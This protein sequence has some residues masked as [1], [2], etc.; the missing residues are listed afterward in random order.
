MKDSVVVVEVVGSLRKRRAPSL[1]SRLRK[2]VAGGRRAQRE[3]FECILEI[4]R[5]VAK[6]DPKALPALV[7]LVGRAAQA[8]AMTTVLR[9][10]QDEADCEYE[11][12]KVL[13]DTSAPLTPDGRSLRRLLREIPTPRALE[14]GVDLLFPSPWERGRLVNSLCNLR[15]GG[16]WGRWRQDPNHRVMLW[17]PLGVGWV[18]GGNHS[19]AAGVIHAQGKVRPEVTYDIS[20]VYKHVVCDGVDYRRVHD[21]SR[22]GPV[23]DLEMATIFEI[24]RLIHKHRV[25]F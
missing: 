17:L 5:D 13:F 21:G 19:V 22:I 1:L 4:A 9:Y 10:P 2:R 16:R 6:R 12:D 20:K 25:S 18:I 7:K 3:E 14:L 8:R 23:P 24:G 11:D 15:P